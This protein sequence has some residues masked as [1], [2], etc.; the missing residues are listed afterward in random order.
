MAR[1]E[2]RVSGTTLYGDTPEAVIEHFRKTDPSIV[3]FVTEWI[4]RPDLETPER[5][6]IESNTPGN[7]TP[8]PTGREARARERAAEHAFHKDFDTEVQMHGR[9][10]R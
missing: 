4:N 8:L 7:I 9:C 3:P 1:P 6:L 2:V 10:P 5:P